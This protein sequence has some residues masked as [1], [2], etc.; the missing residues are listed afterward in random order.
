MSRTFVIDGVT[1]I[2]PRDAARVVHL[3][4]NYISRMARAGFV[5]G[6]LVDKM[7]SVNVASLESFIADQARQK[8]I[9]YAELARK[10]RE[11]QLLAGHP[12]SRSYPWIRASMRTGSSSTICPPPRRRAPHLKYASGADSHAAHGDHV[13]PQDMNFHIGILENYLQNI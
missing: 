1:Y 2:R 12:S 7:W 3:T 4:H 9:F 5:Q 10:R 8:Q 13:V 6:R 11:E